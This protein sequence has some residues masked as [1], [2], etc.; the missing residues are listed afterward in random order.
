MIRYRNKINLV[1]RSAGKL[2]LETDMGKKYEV[3]PFNTSGH[4]PIGDWWERIADT[5]LS[6]WQKDVLVREISTAF[7]RRPELFVVYD[8]EQGW[9][10]QQTHGILFVRISDV[11]ILSTPD[12][13][14]VMQ[15]GS[16]VFERD[17]SLG[18]IMDRNTRDVIYELTDR[19]KHQLRN[20]HA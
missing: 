14:W 15:D 13:L 10:Q 5:E 6:Q 17:Q 8:L 12:D 20:S 19:I 18:S 7:D 16:M 3:T 1:N 2:H 11:T 9:T 4:S